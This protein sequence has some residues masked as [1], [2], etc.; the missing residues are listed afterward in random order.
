MTRIIGV[1]S[2]FGD[3][4]VGW[5]VIESMASG[6]A[7]DVELVKLDR[8]GAT[9]VHWFDD[10]EEVIIIDAMRTGSEIG[11]IRRFDVHELATLA[12]G[13]STHSLGVS[14]TLQLAWALGTLPTRL[15]VIGIEIE[16][17]S[18]ANWAQGLSAN[19]E[20][21]A[22]TVANRLLADYS[23]ECRFTEMDRR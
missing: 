2:P 6:A 15:T 5:R 19:A 22:Q 18:N 4:A 21:A 9:L 1:G 10:I 12:A 7:E 23:G 8:P 3:D 14:E 20:I 13:T 11:T 17:E 16:I